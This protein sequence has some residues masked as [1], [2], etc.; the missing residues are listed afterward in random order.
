[1]VKTSHLKYCPSQK[2]VKEK[3]ADILRLWVAMTDY[4]KEMNISDEI[5]N[6]V[7][8]SYRRIRNTSKFLLSNIWI[9]IMRI[10]K[11]MIW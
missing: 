11:M 3:G 9:T 4:S 1:M 5:I 8:E 7:S 2:I 6:R 10:S